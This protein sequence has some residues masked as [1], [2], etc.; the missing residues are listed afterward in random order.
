[1]VSY[2]AIFF[3]QFSWNSCKVS[4]I[5]L[6]VSFIT[7]MSESGCI[8]NFLAISSII[9]SWVGLNGSDQSHIWAHVLLWR[10]LLQFGRLTFG[11]EFWPIR[12][13]VWRAL[14]SLKDSLQKV[15]VFTVRAF[16][17]ICGSVVCSVAW[18]T[19]LWVF[20]LWKKQ[21]EN[22]LLFYLDFFPHSSFKWKFRIT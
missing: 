7:I 8:L 4:N 22:I 5:G 16:V 2:Q 9:Q 13:L 19:N 14:L 12:G 20:Y 3:K 17:K 15:V 11:A 18:Y 21:K 10:T 6:F 1:M